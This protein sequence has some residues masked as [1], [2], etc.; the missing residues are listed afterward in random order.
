MTTLSATHPTVFP[1]QSLRRS[2]VA[3]IALWTTQILV[4]GMFLYA[5][6]AKLT[7]DPS[8]VALFE[9]VGV[10]Q[11]LRYATGTIEAVSALALIVPSLAAFGALLLI[12]T[13][14]A[15]V[16]THLFIL[17]GTPAPAM[18][19]LIGSIA[20]AWA[21]RDQLTGALSTKH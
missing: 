11:W 12:P 17:G 15:A 20:I 21:R 19:L 8:M 4:A 9:A 16:A 13:M 6:T 1:T 10:G 3:G 18:V 14:V 5:G 2:R 7:G